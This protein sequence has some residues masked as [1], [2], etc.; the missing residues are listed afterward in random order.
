MAG[1][2]PCKGR[3]PW[4]GVFS[5]E[6]HGQRPFANATA[7]R[8]GPTT[9][10]ERIMTRAGVARLSTAFVASV[11]LSGLVVSAQPGMNRFSAV[12]TGDSR[13]RRCPP[14]PRHAHDRYRRGERKNPVGV[15]VF[16]MQDDSTT[17]DDVTQAQ[18]ASASRLRARDCLVVLQDDADDGPR[19]HQTCRRPKPRTSGRL[20]AGIRHGHRIAADHRGGF[21]RGGR[22]HQEGWRTATCTP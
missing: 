18:I 10:E 17:G 21:R 3:K 19:R 12:L 13:C 6:S 8:S 4:T 11:C 22:R 2:P 1:H 7:G 9:Y 15:D 20:Y 5:A 14:T 16:G